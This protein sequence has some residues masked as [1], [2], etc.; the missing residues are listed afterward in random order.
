LEAESA[1]AVAGT[2]GAAAPQ[3]RVADRV[4]IVAAKFA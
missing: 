1:T 3:T 2:R 4:L